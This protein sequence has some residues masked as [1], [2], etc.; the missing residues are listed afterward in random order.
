MTD[1]TL[2]IPSSTSTS[3]N[4]IAVLSLLGIAAYWLSGRI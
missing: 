4:S 3:E 1:K 2:N